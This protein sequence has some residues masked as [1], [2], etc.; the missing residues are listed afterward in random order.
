MVSGAVLADAQIC[1]MGDMV[2]KVGIGTRVRIFAPTLRR[3]RYVGRV[4]SLDASEVTLDTAGVRRRLGFETGPGLVESYRRVGDLHSA[5]PPRR[6]RG[7]RLRGGRSGSRLGTQW[8]LALLPHR[9]FDTRGR[10]FLRS[11]G[12]TCRTPRAPATGSETDDVGFEWFLRYPPERKRVRNVRTLDCRDVDGD[13]DRDTDGLGAH[14][15][16]DTDSGSAVVREPPG[17]RG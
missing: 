15:E 3:D 17:L 7:A 6:R 14:A 11:S 16:A 13:P 1:K 10:A 2:R 12:H 5:A 8:S 9:G 4:D